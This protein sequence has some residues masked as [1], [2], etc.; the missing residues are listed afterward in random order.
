MIAGT[1]LTHINYVNIGG[2]VK[3]IDTIKYYQ[4][5]LAEWV[6]TFTEYK[7]NSEKYLTKQFFNQRYHFSKIWKYL[8]DAQKNKILDIIS[9]GKKIIP[10]GKLVDMNSM[11]LTPENNVF[12]EKTEF[13]S[14]LKQKAVSD[15]DLFI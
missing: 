8:G 12:S 5:I 9:E 10:Y 3:F 6:P 4:K 13:C 1:N 14:D 15:S 2:E 7:K 11:F